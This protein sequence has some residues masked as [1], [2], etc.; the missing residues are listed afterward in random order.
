LYAGDRQG[1][2]EAAA[3]QTLDVFAAAALDDGDQLQ[4]ALATD[5]EAVRAR[6]DDGFTAL[7]LAAFFG[8]ANGVARLLAQGSDPAS[9]AQN[10]MAVTALHSAAAHGDVDIVRALLEAGSPVNAQQAGGYTALHAAA[11]QGTAPLVAVLLAH[12]ADPTLTDDQGSSARDYALKHGHGELA[13]P[14]DFLTWVRSELRDA[15]VAILNGDAAPRRALWSR[16]EPVSILGAARNAFGQRQIYETFDWLASVFSNCTSYDF[17][18]R[19]YDVASDMAYTAGLEH[20][21]ASF[22]GHPRTFTLRATQVYRRED[23]GW[24]VAHRHG[25]EASADGAGPVQPLQSR[26]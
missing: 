3:G 9:I 7:H 18:L 20:V 5:P 16:E 6:T 21:T 8:T 19:S 1:A 15:E 10:A 4:R 12:G 11:M 17:E 23:G 2:T 14:L 25:D 13:S 24:R 22:D 26:S